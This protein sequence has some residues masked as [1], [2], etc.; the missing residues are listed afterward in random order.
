[1]KTRILLLLTFSLIAGNSFAQRDTT[2][3]DSKQT[4]LTIAGIYGNNA[5][6]YGQTAEQKLPFIL[7]NASLRLKNGFYF[8]AGT[9]KLINEGGPFLSVL[10]FSAGFEAD[11]SKNLNAAFAHLPLPNHLRL[12]NAQCGGRRGAVQ[13]GKQHSFAGE[14]LALHSSNHPPKFGFICGTC[15]IL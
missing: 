7:T 5:N 4:T 15:L 10:D 1:M 13:R 8:S 12:T 14:Q 3:E 6:Y 11:I 9:Y 2:Q